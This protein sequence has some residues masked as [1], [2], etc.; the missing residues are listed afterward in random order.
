M[1]LLKHLI[2]SSHN[3]LWRNKKQGTRRI[4]TSGIKFISGWL[5]TKMRSFNYSK[6]MHLFIT[7][8]LNP[9]YRD[10][11]RH[12]SSLNSFYLSFYYVSFQNSVLMTS[13]LLYSVIVFQL[14]LSAEQIVSERILLFFFLCY[15][16]VCLILN[17]AYPISQGIVIC[18]QK[19]YAII[20]KPC[21][22]ENCGTKYNNCMHGHQDEFKL[23]PSCFLS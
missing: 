17:F 11:L 9:L 7:T 2:L 12:I 18:L 3:Y 19:I 22:R 1:E 13:L 20:I 21:E 4:R 15:Y 6:L 14:R 8:S 5:L 10:N 16:Y 23:I